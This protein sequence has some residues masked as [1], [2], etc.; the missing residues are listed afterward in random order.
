MDRLSEGKE[1][2]II[3][4]LDGVTTD[5]DAIEQFMAFV[6]LLGIPLP[7]IQE[8]PIKDYVFMHL[9][10]KGIEFGDN[11]HEDEEEGD[12]NDW[13]VVDV[14]AWIPEDF[15]PGF[16]VE[17]VSEDGI[18]AVVTSEARAPISE[19]IP[20]A[21]WSLK[22]KKGN[23]S[24]F[25]EPP[26]E[27]TESILGNDPEAQPLSQTIQDA[28]KQPVKS[29]VGKVTLSKWD[30]N[31]KI[32]VNWETGE[33]KQFTQ[34]EMLSGVGGP[35]WEETRFITMSGLGIQVVAAI[36]GAIEILKSLNFTN[37]SEVSPVLL[38]IN[39]PTPEISHLMGLLADPLV[40]N[41]LGNK[42]TLEY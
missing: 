19:L 23:L 6:Q 15:G 27:F 41:D 22:L 38:E 1:P 32:M 4:N 5:K 39:D 12:P 7:P 18:D 2:C 11:Y 16:E 20:N 37:Y 14:P 21:V 34:T 31:Q 8:L 17:V 3:T 28:K 10:P 13:S 9:H 36:P 35:E 26:P 25:E 24:C 29:N 30:P 33:V 42:I 40:V